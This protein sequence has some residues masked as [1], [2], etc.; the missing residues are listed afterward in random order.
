LGAAPSETLSYE[1]ATT[2]VRAKLREATMLRMR[3]DV[4]LGVLL[5]G[6]LDSSI[7]VALMRESYE[8]IKTFS[9]GFDNARYNESEY[10][11]A[12]AR[13]FNTDHHAFVVRPDI[14]KNLSAIVWAFDQP[15]ADSSGIAT[16]FLAKETRREVTVAL[17]GDGADESFGG[18]PRYTAAHVY[19]MLNRY[20]H[21]PARMIAAAIRP[22]IDWIPEGAFDRGRRMQLKKF[23]RTLAVRQPF[24]H[25]Y[26]SWFCHF[27]PAQARFISTDSFSR[28]WD[29]AASEYLTEAYDAVAAS[30]LRE[31]VMR[32]DS[33]TYL[34]NDLLVKMDRATMA[35]SLEARSP[36]LDHRVMEFAAG[37]PAAYK[38][39]FAH[40]KIILRDAFRD[41]LPAKVITR[42]KMGFG[43]P[44][45]AWL[46]HDLKNFITHILLSER[47]A[48]RGM[49]QRER[50]ADLIAVHVS[51]KINHGYRLWNL[52][53]LEL[54]FRRFIDN[55]ETV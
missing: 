7:I 10:A 5:S 48:A 13:Y 41:M 30:S 28:S 14:V 17:C 1:E 55:D 11:A 9:I 19:E 24:A 2:G 29:A 43:V 46:K 21:S 44:V 20:P 25:L 12:V 27:T 8:R 38:L 3:S 4:P 15:F 40:R 49:F 16:Y 6:G 50:V 31:R 26:L 36:F 33:V 32:T 37:L 22:L 35:H 39:N 52:L 23:I 45:G 53:M 51:G 54:W 47:A 34:P 42:K 18:Y